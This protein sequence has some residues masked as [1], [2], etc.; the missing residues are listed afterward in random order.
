MCL[1]G[2]LTA[3]TC[4]SAPAPVELPSGQSGPVSGSATKLAEISSPHQG[5]QPCAARFLRVS[6]M[7][8]QSDPSCKG[9][10]ETSFKFV[11]R[12]EL[13]FFCSSSMHPNCSSERDPVSGLEWELKKAVHNTYCPS[14]PTKYHDI[15]VFLSFVVPEHCE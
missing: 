2:N 14:R 15:T 3:T 5:P 13:F 11:I 7:G 1:S 9:V 10:R 8:P 12:G 4:C 6:H